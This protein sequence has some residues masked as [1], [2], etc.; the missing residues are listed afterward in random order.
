MAEPGATPATPEP[1]SRSSDYSPTVPAADVER[2]RR[3]HEDAYRS[4][5]ALGE[6]VIE[7]LGRSF[8]VPPE[9]QPI[10]PTSSLLGEAVLAEVRPDDRVLDMGTGSGVNAILAAGTAREVVAVDINP[11]AL[12]AARRNAERNGVADRIDVR[13][14]DVFSAV[15]GRFDLIVFDPPFRWFAP[16]DLTER[17]TTDENYRAMTAFFRQ[18]RRHLTE[19]GRMLVFF[20]TSGDLG[21][22]E[23][24]IAEEG[25]A[26]EVVARAELTKEG[27]RVEYLTFRLTP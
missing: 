24:L 18:A 12:A 14:S 4:R 9:V 3:W 7:Y 10:T 17:A 19:R 16:R 2:I 20:G 6:Q 1:S 25:F 22:L 8:V 21:Y 27:W 11:H 26:K 23:R 13:H 5:K 15:D